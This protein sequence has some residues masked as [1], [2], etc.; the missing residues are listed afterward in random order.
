[1]HTARCGAA[2]VAAVRA[3]S[4]LPTPFGILPVSQDEH[5]LCTDKVR[6]V[7][8]PLAAVVAIDELTAF[9]ALDL[10]QVDYGKLTTIADPNEAL[11]MEQPRLH[12]YGDH[13][14]IHKKV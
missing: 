1:V 8:D 5:A 3:G 4:E 11:T 14:N 13:G 7:G 12:E 10:I 2:C 6:F 9:E